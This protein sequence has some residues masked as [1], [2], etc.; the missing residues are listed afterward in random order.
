MKALTIPFVLFCALIT[1]SIAGCFDMDYSDSSTKEDADSIFETIDYDISTDRQ[2]FW[3]EENYEVVIP[4]PALFKKYAD[5]GTFTLE[6]INRNL[7]LELT[8]VAIPE[9]AR[10]ISL[11]NGPDIYFDGQ[12]PQ[13]VFIFE[14]KV[15]NNTESSAWFSGSE[16]MGYIAGEIVNGNEEYHIKG[17][18]NG[19]VYNGKF[20]EIIYLSQYQSGNLNLTV[21]P[22][23]TKVKDNE[24]FD[25][26]LTLTNTGNNTLNIWKLYEQIS[27]DLYFRSSESDNYA[28]YSCGELQRVPMTN[29]DTEELESGESISTTLNSRCWE[30][31]PGEYTLYGV[32]RTLKDE[33]VAK[34]YWFGEI[35][36]EEIK[37][38]VDE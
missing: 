6:L 3:L 28:Y 14:G 16:S 20:V 36:S 35:K 5:S 32:Y 29:D 13:E 31:E 26:H 18:S 4:N 34:P 11:N 33:M 19:E 30:L 22:E 23:K 8:E 25:I 2:Y 15:V 7:E 37:V 9:G 38:L 24:T 17:T 27:Y 12:D 10:K 21:V 1:V